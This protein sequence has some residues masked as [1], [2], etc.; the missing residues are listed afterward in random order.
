MIRDGRV[1]YPGSEQYER[2][3]KKRAC[4]EVWLTEKEIMGTEPIHVEGMSVGQ[5]E[6]TMRKQNAQG[7][8][9]VAYSNRN[10]QGQE[11]IGRGSVEGTP[12][13]NQDVR[14]DGG[15]N[16]TD[17]RVPNTSHRGNGYERERMEHDRPLASTSRIIKDKETEDEIERIFR[18]VK[19]VPKL[20]SPI[21]NEGIEGEESN[22]NDRNVLNVGGRDQIWDTEEVY[23]D[24]GCGEVT[25]EEIGRFERTNKREMFKRVTRLEILKVNLSFFD[26]S[27]QERDVKVS[28]MCHSKRFW[29]AVKFCRQKTKGLI[30]NRI[31]EIFGVGTKVV[32]PFCH[33]SGKNLSYEDYDFYAPIEYMGKYKHRPQYVIDHASNLED[34]ISS[35]TIKIKRTTLKR[36]RE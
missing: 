20:I 18:M 16:Y 10:V 32:L 11:V 3:S 5:G 9:E 8:N 14:E 31:C 2:I 7:E 36:K 19:Y 24:D 28:R 1:W 22:E 29:L 34:L 25:E 33:G 4:K 21:K 15:A 27:Q 23:T 17:D 13:R 6:T 30:H 26:L 12:G 35:G